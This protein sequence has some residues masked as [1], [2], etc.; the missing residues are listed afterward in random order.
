MQLFSSLW[1]RW[2]LA[3]GSLPAV[4]TSALRLVGLLLF[5]SLFYMFLFLFNKILQWGLPLLYF[6]F[7][8]KCDLQTSGPG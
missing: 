2:L 7:K 5:L 4:A 3:C 8:K 6:P 1:P